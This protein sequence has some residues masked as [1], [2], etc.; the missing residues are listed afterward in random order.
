MK[1]KPQF[2]ELSISG[3]DA[4]K[5]TI[6][7]SFSSEDPYE[8]WW[9]IEVLGHDSE[10]VDLTRLNNN[11]PLLFNH[12]RDQYIGVIESAYIKDKRGCSVVRLG[13][14]DQANQI[15]QDI[16]DG[17]LSKVSVGYEILEMRLESESNGV[18]TYRVTRWKPY[19]VSIVTIPA[20]DTVG[21][22]RDAE[23]TEKEIT[24]K[25][26][27]S[28]VRKMDEDK[29][30]F[31]N[32]EQIKSDALKEERV[33]VQEIKA[34]GD[35]LGY[36]DLADEAI[37][38]G[39]SL[40]SFRAAVIKLQETK[41]NDIDTKST[42][43]GMNT[44]EL[45]QYSFSKLL[46][47]LADPSNRRAQDDAAFEFEMSRE[48][49][50]KSG[51]VAQGAIIPFDVFARD[52]TVSGTSGVTVAT[53]KGG[54]IEV[55]KNKSVMMKLATVLS[56]LNGNVSFPKQISSTTAYELTEIQ[57]IT[58]SDI[59]L[60]EVILSPKRFGAASSYSKQI[61]VQSS[62]DIE[63]LIQNDLLSQIGL[64]IDRKAIDTILATVGVGLVALGTNGAAPTNSTFV[65]LET[66]VAVD[67]ADIGRLAYLI[68]A[69]TRGFLKKTPVVTGN[70]KMIL[71][72]DMINGYG[73]FATNQI[74]GDLT[75]GTGTNL[76]ALLF[77]NFADLLVGLWGGIDLIVD[78]YTSKNKGLIEVTADQFADVGVRRAESF[79]V[80]KDAVIG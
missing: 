51:L 15:F 60:S 33:R 69:R 6:E 8:R 65:D 17:I 50:I 21:I 53:S 9:G 46:K 52:L 41:S 54:L 32:A 42:S 47:A 74:P 70:P 12:N 45:K 10:N 25:S 18:E 1:L 23:L 36:K 57:E 77:G 49:E 68:N 20:D 61:L 66:E 43:T 55:L 58:K 38:K 28:E 2:R 72:G 30:T 44:K 34:I 75:K 39:T 13:T 40:D 31:A 73:Y 19:E 62:P 63:M 29:A 7:L 16:K 22:G 76:S 67:N 56:G 11:A 71:E 5:R 79:A 80:S 35:K 27:K 26:N 64:K 37:A 24:I 48:A 59:G 3:F 78:P 14:N 4:E